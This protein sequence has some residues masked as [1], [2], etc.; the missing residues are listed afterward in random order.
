MAEDLSKILS[1]TPIYE[2]DLSANLMFAPMLYNEENET[3]QIKLDDIVNWF[4]KANQIEIEQTGNNNGLNLHSA[5][6][7]L[8]RRDGVLDAEAMF[9]FTKRGYKKSDAYKGE[10]EEELNS[11]YRNLFSFVDEFPVIEDIDWATKNIEL[12]QNQEVSSPP[13]T[14]KTHQYSSFEKL[15]L[16][17][18]L[19]PLEIRDENYQILLPK[20]GIEIELSHLTKSIY[21]LFLLH[22]EIRLTNLKEH[23]RELLKI[24][25]QVSNRENYDQMVQSVE[26]VIN[27]ETNAIYVHLSRIKAAFYSKLDWGIAEHYCI[28]G[29]RNEPKSIKLSRLQGKVLLPLK[30]NL[31]FLT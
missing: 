15:F 31:F 7:S 9:D 27:L 24:Y 4:N 28:S 2:G 22:E 12:I 17:E 19:S 3:H 18:I 21:I 14:L 20:Y 6:C 26:D 25:K 8:I 29:A 30:L 1:L 11:V 10:T 13:I 16:K 23:K 5:I